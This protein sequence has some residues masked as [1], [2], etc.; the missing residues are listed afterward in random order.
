MSN[1]LYL[2]YHKYI[3]INKNR[4]IVYDDRIT[5]KKDFSNYIKELNLNSI[6]KLIINFDPNLKFKKIHITNDL[7]YRN[8]LVYNSNNLKV[9]NDSKCT[10]LNNAIYKNNL[11]NSSNKILILGGKFK[12]QDKNQKYNITNTLVLIFGDQ[13]DLFINQLKFI[14][15]N[16][17]KFN[18]LN[19][20]FMFLKLIIK[21]Y[22][23]EF[24]LFSPG[25]ES[26]DS[27]KNY[28]DRGK[29]FNQL[30]KKVLL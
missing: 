7:N 27:Y 9:Y 28:L 24:I 13:K 6:K 30:I 16:Y 29:H 25:G 10:N 23:Y 12:K 8:Q 2:K 15:S 5:I 18:N 19:E 20:L 26:Y 11:I 3:K 4:L 1:K 14:H 21:F 22:K 17:F